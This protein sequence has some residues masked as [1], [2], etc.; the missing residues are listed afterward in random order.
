MIHKRWIATGSFSLALVIGMGA[1]GAHALHDML[2]ATGRLE[3][4]HTAVQYH[5]YHSFGLIALGLLAP[6]L[7]GKKTNIAGMLFLSGIVL[8][9]GSLYILCFTGISVL[10]MITPFGGVAFIAGWLWLGFGFT[11]QKE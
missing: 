11:R 9:S 7:P 6:Y 10:G 2:A 5:F 1:F 8:F 3:T 4:Y